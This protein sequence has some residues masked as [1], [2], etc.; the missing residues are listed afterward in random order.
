MVTITN[1]SKKNPRINFIIENEVKDKWTKF[2]EN[3]DEISTIS[4]LIRM[5]VESFIE[6]Q[7]GNAENTKVAKYAHR[8]KEE[9]SSIKGYSQMLIDEFKDE[10]PFEKLKKL[11]YIYKNSIN[12][13]N[14]INLIQN[15][16]SVEKEE[17]DV[18]IVDDNP[19]AINLITDI[20]KNKGLSYK[21]ASSGSSALELLKISKPKLILLDILLPGRSDGYEICKNIKSNNNLKSIPIYFITAV[22]EVE[23]QKRYEDAGAKGYILKPFEVK[24]FNSVIESI[25]K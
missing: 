25:K 2:V 22:P 9:L 20:L 4:K 17:F 23:V 19:D 3:N 5:A 10:W 18:L 24:N 8:I 15:P 1:E 14:I 7:D 16:Q 11:T 6:Q 21:T 12:I 13:E